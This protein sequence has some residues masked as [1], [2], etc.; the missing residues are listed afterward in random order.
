MGTSI[1]IPSTSHPHAPLP[2]PLAPPPVSQ[3]YLTRAVGTPTPRPRFPLPGILR[4]QPWPERLEGGDVLASPVG[5]RAPS[6]VKSEAR[7]GP[8]SQQIEPSVESG[9]LWV[10]SGSCLGLGLLGQGT[11][12]SSSSSSSTTH[13]KKHLEGWNQTLDPGH[14]PTEPSLTHPIRTRPDRRHPSRCLLLP[15]CWC[16]CWCW[17]CR[18]STL[19]FPSQPPLT[20]ARAR[21]LPMPLSLSFSSSLSLPDNFRVSVVPP[22]PPCPALGVPASPP[23]SSH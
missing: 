2:P 5:S 21:Q 14:W 6:R 17:C 20:S 12:S 15:G 19:L 23:I 11:S 13:Q 9:D 10:V 1:H 8:P 3:N 4:L 16:W 22:R 18:C 7:V